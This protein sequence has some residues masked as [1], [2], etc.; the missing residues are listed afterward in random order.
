MWST[1]RYKVLGQNAEHW[2]AELCA[3]RQHTSMLERRL[4]LAEMQADRGSD[5]WDSNRAILQRRIVDAHIQIEQLTAQVE[6]LR[7]QLESRESLPINDY[8]RRML[9]MLPGRR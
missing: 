8:S 5:D 7:I 2:Y 3:N 9:D 1:R 6:R 4:A